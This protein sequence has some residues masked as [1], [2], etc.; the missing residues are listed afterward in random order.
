V[1]G[2]RFHSEIHV[3]RSDADENGVTDAFYLPG[4]CNVRCGLAICFAAATASET[5]CL[6]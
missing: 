2:E 1:V 5:T 3:F 4:G 6:T